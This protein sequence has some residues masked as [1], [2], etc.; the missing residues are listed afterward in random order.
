[1]CMKEIDGYTHFLMNLSRNIHNQVNLFRKTKN[2]YI[3]IEAG[4]GKKHEKTMA[5]KMNKK[6]NYQFEKCH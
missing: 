5:S 2:K 4:K 3:Q 1:M 6:R